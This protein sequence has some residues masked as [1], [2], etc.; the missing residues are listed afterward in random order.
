MESKEDNLNSAATRIE[1]KKGVRTE[2]VIQRKSSFKYQYLGG[3]SG[4][5]SSHSYLYLSWSLIG[6]RST[7]STTADHFPSDLISSQS[8][9]VTSYF[10]SSLD[11]SCRHR[12][13]SNYVKCASPLV[14]A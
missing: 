8:K 9:T 6:V 4:L 12:N 10:C 5:F 1:N 11:T 14:T 2:Q 7:H 3:C 13:Y